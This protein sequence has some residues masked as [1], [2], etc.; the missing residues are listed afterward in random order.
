MS[1]CTMTM[2][3]RLLAIMG[4]GGAVFVAHVGDYVMLFL[5]RLLTSLVD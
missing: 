2:C 4:D 3:W 1:F 5:F